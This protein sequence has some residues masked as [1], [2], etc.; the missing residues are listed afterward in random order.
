MLRKLAYI[1]FQ[2]LKQVRGKKIIKFSDWFQ[3]RKYFVFTKFTYLLIL[4][5]LKFFGTDIFWIL[6]FKQYALTGV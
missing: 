1:G 6:L 2:W 3:C 5:S 4:E